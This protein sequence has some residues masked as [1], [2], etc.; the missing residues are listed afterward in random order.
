MADTCRGCGDRLDYD[1]IAGNAR[2]GDEWC[3]TCIDEMKDEHDEA[4]DEAEGATDDDL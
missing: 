3:G 2:M 1:R 4:A